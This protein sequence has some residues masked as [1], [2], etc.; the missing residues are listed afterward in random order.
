MAN[1]DEEADKDV[2]NRGEL[3]IDAGCAEDPALNGNEGTVEAEDE[4][5]TMGK[6]N[7]EGAVEAVADEDDDD[8][9]KKE[10]EGT[11]EG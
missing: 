9:D 11:E 3:E 10:K 1:V 2:P 6:P 7:D 5:E 4:V 8:V